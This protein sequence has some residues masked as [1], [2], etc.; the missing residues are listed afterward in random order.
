MAWASQQFPGGGAVFV[1][2]WGHNLEI[3][4]NRIHNNQGTVSGGITVGQGEHPDGYLAGAAN[5]APGSCQLTPV[6]LRIL[7][8]RTAST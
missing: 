2:A 7:S 1:H 5:P 6:F 4:N 8:Y 3:A